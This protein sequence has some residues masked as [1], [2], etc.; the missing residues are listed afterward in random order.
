MTALE[1]IAQLVRDLQTVGKLQ[2]EDKIQYEN[3]VGE[4][5][6]EVVSLKIVLHAPTHRIIETIQQ[7]MKKVSAIIKKEE[8]TWSSIY[9]DE[10]NS[11]VTL[12]INFPQ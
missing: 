10:S 6:R 5:K 8:N 9:L 4:N 12:E 2:Q 11:A 1:R 3:F 7:S